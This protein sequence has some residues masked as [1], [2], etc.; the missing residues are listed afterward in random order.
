MNFDY[1]DY[2]G[3]TSSTGYERLLHDCMMG[4]ATL[5]QRADQVEA[6]WSVVAPIQAAWNSAA[7]PPFPNYKAGTWG[8]TEADELLARDGREWERTTDI[9]EK[10][11]SRNS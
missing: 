10:I 1:E 2:F 7:P 11:S 3:N 9:H 8:P 6:A 5:F 4:E